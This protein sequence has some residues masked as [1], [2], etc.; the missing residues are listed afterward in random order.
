MNKTILDVCCGPKMMWFQKNNPAVLF[1]DKRRCEKG[2]MR[3]RPNCEVKP[4]I[5]ADFR[6]LP[7]QDNS[8]SLVVFD[9]PHTIRARETRGII[10]ERYGRLVLST[11]ERDLAQGFNECWRVLKS[12]GTLI[13]KWSECDKK[14][15][16][17]KHLFP[18]PVLFGTRVGKDNKT[19]WICFFKN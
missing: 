6:D 17:I 14:I 2:F 16:E 8:F 3:T 13:F 5:Q 11:W 15:D 1:V 12:N 4:D 10:A 7:F 9:P 19:L 18:G